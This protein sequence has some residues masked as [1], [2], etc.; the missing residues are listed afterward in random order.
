MP[1][2]TLV[3]HFDIMSPLL[4]I[5]WA[6]GRMSFHQVRALD[7]IAQQVG[8]DDLAK[9]ISTVSVG[10]DLTSPPPPSLRPVIYA[11]AVWVAVIDGRLE[12]RERRLL[13]HFASSWD[14]DR[15]VEQRARSLALRMASLASGQPT[16]AQL[17][18]LFR[19][20]ERIH[21]STTAEEAA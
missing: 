6:D 15:D 17:E 13:D 12:P 1:F 16:Q 18:A 14:L 21:G 9:R 3:Q 19:A 11:L 5:L 8:V 4:D 20:A 10:D 2:P 7:L